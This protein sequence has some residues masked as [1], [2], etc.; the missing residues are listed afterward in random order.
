LADQPARLADF[1]DF[2]VETAAATR[3][4]T[5]FHMTVRVRMVQ[6]MF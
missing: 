6:F 5:K 4:E 1:D 3:A 2:F